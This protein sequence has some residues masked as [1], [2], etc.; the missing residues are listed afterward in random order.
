VTSVHLGV[1]DKY[2]WQ[3]KLSEDNAVHFRKTVE[4]TPQTTT[5]V[6]DNDNNSV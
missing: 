3:R 5:L 1:M 2:H 4:T 6:E